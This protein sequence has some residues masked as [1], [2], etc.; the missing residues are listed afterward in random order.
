V[1]AATG[2]WSSDA[3]YHLDVSTRAVRGNPSRVPA[4][5]YSPGVRALLVAVFPRRRVAS[6]SPS[7]PGVSLCRMRVQIWC[8]PPEPP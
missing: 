5:A 4:V 6:S 1:L 3:A 7:S 2:V 8:P